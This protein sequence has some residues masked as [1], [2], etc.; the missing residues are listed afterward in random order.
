MSE[1]NNAPGRRCHHVFKLVFG[2]E[3]EAE[4]SDTTWRDTPSKVVVRPGKVATLVGFVAAD[5]EARRGFLLLPDEA[6]HLG[7][8]LQRNGALSKAMGDFT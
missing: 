5:G 6:I 1:Q 2:P 7:L 4:W 8:S 3:F